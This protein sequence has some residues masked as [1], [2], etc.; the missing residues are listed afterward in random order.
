MTIGEVGGE[1]GEEVAAMATVDEG[2]AEASWGVETQV[3]AVQVT[4]SLAAEVVE[5]G[6]VVDD[7]G[8]AM[9]PC[10][11]SRFDVAGCYKQW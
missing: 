4:H 5:A 6:V 11:D 2:V 3:A 1:E 7:V 9:I 10:A 8:N